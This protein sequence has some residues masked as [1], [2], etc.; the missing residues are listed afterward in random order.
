[1]MNRIFNKIATSRKF[2]EVNRK[3]GWGE[4]SVNGNDK[5]I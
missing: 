1:M 3:K 4:N 2:R 5:S